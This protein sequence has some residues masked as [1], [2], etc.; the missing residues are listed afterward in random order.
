MKKIDPIFTTYI[1]VADLLGAMFKDII[2]IVIHDF[3]DLDRA[4]IH[5]V[6]GHISGREAGAPISEFGLRRLIEDRKLPDQI[7]NFASQNGRGKSLKSSSLAIRD[8]K[9]KI[10][11]A[12][13]LHFDISYFTQFQKFLGHFM[14]PQDNS[15]PN[16]SEFSGNQ[17]LSDEVKSEIEK[18]RLQKGLFNT[19]LNRKDKIALVQHLMKVGFLQKK[20]AI[21]TI[22]QAL[23]LTRQSIY[24]YTKEKV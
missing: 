16:V 13:C 12:F 9:G 3:S 1:K 22:A 5:I 18:W 20:A 15:F 21:A 7:V 19:S 4:I 24:N 17:S 10:R 8:S 11:G 14:A 23:Q 6:N 2:E